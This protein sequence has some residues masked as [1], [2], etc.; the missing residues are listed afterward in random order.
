VEKNDWLEKFGGRT[1]AEFLQKRQKTGRK[2]YFKENVFF[3][4]EY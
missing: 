3:L 4:I 1:A 2:K